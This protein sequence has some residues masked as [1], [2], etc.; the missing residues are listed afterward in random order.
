MLPLQS[1]EASP[2]SN[3]ADENGEI[4]QQK[5]KTLPCKYCSKRFR[6]VLR[7]LAPSASSILHIDL[8]CPLILG[9]WSMSNDT[10]EPIQR[11]N[12]LPAAGLAVGKH[13]DDGELILLLCRVCFVLALRMFWAPVV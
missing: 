8:H 3:T 1:I 10:R 2:P 6:S 5:P 7:K 12:P 13:L 9:V 11:R 4:R